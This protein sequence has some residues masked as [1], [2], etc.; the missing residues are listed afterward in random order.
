MSQHLICLTIDTDPDGLNTHNPD[1]SDLSWDGLH[2]AMREF[3]EALPDIPLTWYVRADGQLEAAYGSVRWMMETYI[4][5]WREAIQR[6]DELGWHP[7]LYSVPEQGEPQI[8]RESETA[9]AELK[10]IHARLQ[11]VP[12]D[13][14]SFRMGE[15][16]HTA[17][18]LNLLEQL[19]YTIDSTAIP[20]RDDSAS[21]HPRNWA[22][23][24]NYCYYPDNQSP[25]VVGTKRAL[26]EVP[27][28]TWRFQAS[29]DKSP[30]LR[31]MNPCIHADLWQQALDYWQENLPNH[32][33][34][35]WNLILH[36]AE[37][38]PHDA[39]DLLYAYSLEVMVKNINA[40]VQ[41]I[42]G[43]GDSVAFTTIAHAAQQWRNVIA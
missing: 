16:W 28:N 24:P 18:T 29:Y 13:L 2:F 41:R 21:G 17:A 1:R 11:D 40:L 10:R 27:M 7:H 34:H 3:Y 33:L 32:A 38:M 26:L 30:K 20:D 37:A 43:R 42:E 12:F 9:V 6:G 8:I 22:G 39:P 5:F 25:H 31:Y 35:I 23:A 14:K 36:P 4:D 19:G 15:A